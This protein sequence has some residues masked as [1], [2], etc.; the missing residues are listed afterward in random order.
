MTLFALRIVKLMEN[1][2][3]KSVE[4]M[5][6]LYSITGIQT[7]LLSNIDYSNKFINSVGL[8]LTN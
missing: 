1:I 7:I 2:I 6:Y 8:N 3:M 5:M 4:F